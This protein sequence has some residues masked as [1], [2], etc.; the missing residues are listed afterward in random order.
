MRASSTRMTEQ[1]EERA[2]E[3]ERRFSLATG[4]TQSRGIWGSSLRTTSEGN[5]RSE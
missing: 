3:D 1:E 5:S 4:L 2:D